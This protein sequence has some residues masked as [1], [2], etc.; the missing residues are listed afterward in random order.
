MPMTIQ[1]SVLVWT[2]ICFVLL[3]LILHHLLFQPV[4]KV[5][6]D[7]KARIQSAAKKKAEHER[8]TEQNAAALREREA[9]RLAA[10]RRQIKEQI[11]TIRQQSKKTLEDAKDK[12]LR[13][14]D[15][16]RRQAEA[17][18]VE[19]LITLSAHAA[20]LAAAFAESVIEG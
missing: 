12:R 16:Y 1:L 14:V 20:E 9:A 4:L 3:M 19:I 6:D 5:M 13:A 18:R 17:E 11:E 15:N 8:L 10:R 7:R 2:I